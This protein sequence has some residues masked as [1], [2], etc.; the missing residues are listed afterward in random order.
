MWELIADTQIAMSDLLHWMA[1][2][3][4][5]ILLFTFFIFS[6]T[7][8]LILLL[9]QI[10]MT[11]QEAVDKLNTANTQLADINTKVD[12]LLANQGSVSPELETAING[13]SDSVGTLAA[14]LP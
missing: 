10:K 14:K 6:F 4:V 1:W 12:T 13:V 11:N 2:G 9:N 3:L 8:Y 7:L 5:F